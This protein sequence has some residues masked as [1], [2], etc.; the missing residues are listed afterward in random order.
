M[1]DSICGISR[2]GLEHKELSKEIKGNQGEAA[3]G[4][5]APQMP[6]RIETAP[7]GKLEEGHFRVWRCR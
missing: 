7:S 6:P 5:S 3:N 2:P 1:H 4:R